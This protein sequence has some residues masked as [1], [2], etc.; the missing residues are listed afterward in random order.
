M[1]A[2]QICAH[3]NFSFKKGILL[4]FSLLLLLL[5]V[6][7]YFACMFVC[8]PHVCPWRSEKDI[9]FPRPGV[10]EGSCLAAEPSF[11]PHIRFPTWFFWGVGGDQGLSTEPWLS[12]NSICRPGW[13]Q[14]QRSAC[15]FLL[16][17]GIKGMCLRALLS[18]MVFEGI[19]AATL[20]IA[21][22]FMGWN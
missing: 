16:S 3:A 18:S 9:G 10:M 13:S 4:L 8:A 22:L 19:F 6:Y 17:T 2:A 21:S 14:T 12:W 7:E 5:Y 1:A 11:L 15:L 20:R